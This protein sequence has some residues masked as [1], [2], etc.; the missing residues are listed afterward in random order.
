MI[1]SLPFLGLAA[2]CGYNSL[3]YQFAEAAAAARADHPYVSAFLK[4]AL[5]FLGLA[6]AAF[7]IVAGLQRLW[8]RRH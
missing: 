4:A 6:V 5:F 7:L 3:W 1:A 2:F 8:E